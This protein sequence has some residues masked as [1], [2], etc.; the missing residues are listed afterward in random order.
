MARIDTAVQAILDPGERLMASRAVA[1]AGSI[2]SRSGGGF[3]FGI[4]GQMFADL[5]S[6]AHGSIRLDRRTNLLVITGRRVVLAQTR[7][8]RVVE[9]FA[10]IPRDEVASIEGQKAK[11]AIGKL[12][13]RLSSG[14]EIVLDLVS[15]RRLDEFLAEANA[16]LPAMP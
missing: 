4:G 16:A 15:D 2:A 8:G 1:T 3:L 14:E 5:G 7:L 10:M 6:D 13:L 9:V 11:V 12:S